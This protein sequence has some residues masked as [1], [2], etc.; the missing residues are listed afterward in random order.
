MHKITRLL[1]ARLYKVDYEC[2]PLEHV[3][4]DSNR[5]IQYHSNYGNRP[6]N[7][8]RS[9]H[10]S[11]Q[12]DLRS[13]KR[14]T[15]RPLSSGGSDGQL[16]DT[17]AAQDKVYTT[18]NATSSK[19][20]EHPN[21]E[22]SASNAVMIMR[23]LSNLSLSEKASSSKTSDRRSA[24][25]VDIDE[26]QGM[27]FSGID[28]EANG[29]SSS[30]SSHGRSGGNNIKFGIK[31]IIPAPSF[32]S[33]TAPATSPTGPP[34]IS[35]TQA[36]SGSSSI[37]SGSQKRGNNTR[38]TVSIHQFDTL[39]QDS[40]SKLLNFVHHG[41]QQHGDPSESNPRPTTLSAYA[42]D[43]DD[44]K[45]RHDMDR[46]SIASSIDRLAVEDSGTLSS[47]VIE[48]VSPSF[49]IRATHIAYTT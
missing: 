12:A 33:S 26:N 22:S 10:L 2:Q 8:V 21:A 20:T 1:S 43:E 18:D 34:M 16:F 9:R 7:K 23:N 14:S 19:T 39:W 5:A 32:S 11:I 46:K 40:S 13:N 42:K 44:R 25:F 3:T 48:N 38:R 49:F 31:N 17:V 45:S 15:A 30:S 47:K 35:T 29:G 6:R 37:G 41:Q 28:E 36:N 27:S 24:H 4:D